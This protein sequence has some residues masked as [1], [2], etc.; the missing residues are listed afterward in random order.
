MSIAIWCFT[1]NIF[2]DSSMFLRSLNG[3]RRPPRRMW[4]SSG[5]FDDTPKARR[6]EASEAMH[7]CA[8]LCRTVKLQVLRAVLWTKSRK[9]LTFWHDMS[10]VKT[11]Q[12]TE[13]CKAPIL[14]QRIQSRLQGVHRSVMT[15]QLSPPLRGVLAPGRQGWSA[16]EQKN[17][18]SKVPYRRT[19]SKKR[20]VLQVL[21]IVYH[22][23][24]ISAC[25]C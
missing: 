4:L 10:T 9:A 23:H 21:Q 14:V 3:L 2:V 25:P 19:W 22:S 7:W 12:N 15:H 18:L 24:S 8:E 6:P 17:N 16:F 20:L 1:P 5:C 11:C 13:K